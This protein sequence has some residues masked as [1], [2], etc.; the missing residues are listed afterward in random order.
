MKYSI[1]SLTTKQYGSKR[2]FHARFSWRLFSGCTG[3]MTPEEISAAFVGACGGGHVK[4]AKRLIKKGA[5]PCHYQDLVYRFAK[6]NGHEEVV[7]FLED[8]DEWSRLCGFRGAVLSEAR[9]FYSAR[10]KGTLLVVPSSVNTNEATLRGVVNGFCA[11]FKDHHGNFWV[12]L[13]S[14]SQ[15]DH[16]KGHYNGATITRLTWC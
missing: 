15:I 4:L 14:T 7:S 10:L 1:N 5:D 3:Q 6:F 2:L 13:D 11:M 9:I 8:G 12:A 16:I